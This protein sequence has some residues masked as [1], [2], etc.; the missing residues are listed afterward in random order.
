MY[1]IDD[2]SNPPANFYKQVHTKA[3]LLSFWILK[4]LLKYV[5]QRH[6]LHHIMILF[7]LYICFYVLTGEVNS[8]FK[9][10]CPVFKNRKY[11]R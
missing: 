5:C 9:T 6:D 8:I 2:L 1:S 3:P 11:P 4:Y 10:F 7:M